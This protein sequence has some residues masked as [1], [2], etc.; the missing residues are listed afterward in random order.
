VRC[1]GTG[2]KD[3]SKEYYTDKDEE[4]SNREEEVEESNAESALFLV[5]FTWMNRCSGD[6][7]WD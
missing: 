3:V 2:N 7:A 6:I 1:R 5:L 4:V